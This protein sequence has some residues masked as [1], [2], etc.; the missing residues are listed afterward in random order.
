MAT[1]ALALAIFAHAWVHRITA[2]APIINV[3]GWVV[4]GVTLIVLLT[5]VVHCG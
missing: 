4:A 2:P 3:V 1:V 5:Q